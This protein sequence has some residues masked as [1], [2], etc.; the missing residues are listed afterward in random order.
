MV[1]GVADRAFLPRRNLL[2]EAG[3][4]MI[5]TGTRLFWSAN[6]RARIGG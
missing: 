3:G 4:M 1:R 5:L 2:E 6:P